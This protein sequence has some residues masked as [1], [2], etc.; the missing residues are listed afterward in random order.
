MAYEQ[1]AGGQLV[2]LDP[3]S[4]VAG[5]LALRGGAGGGHVADAAVMAHTYRGYEGLLQGRDVRD[6]IFISSRACGVCGGAHASCSALAVEMTFEIRPPHYGITVR[7][8]L[9][10]L[11]VLADHPSHL[12]L[13]AGPDYSEAVVRETNPSLWARAQS[14]A[15]AGVQAHGMRT[16]ADIMTELT[17]FSGILYREAQV[18]SR[19]AREAFVVMGGKYPHPQT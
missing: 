7:N 10:A 1:T 17:R 16:I 4:R 5:A 8:L 19:T 18:M 15:A 12:F 2:E 14:T 9:A 11:E 13:R 3:I 6:A